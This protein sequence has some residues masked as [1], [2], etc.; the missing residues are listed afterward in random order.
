MVIN[1]ALSIGGILS[2]APAIRRHQERVS[3]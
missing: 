1:Q 3:A 2:Q